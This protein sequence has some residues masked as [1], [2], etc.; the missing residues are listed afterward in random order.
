MVKRTLK[1]IEEVGINALSNTRSVER[2]CIK[3]GRRIYR[4]ARDT[5]LMTKRTRTTT[6]KTKWVLHVRKTPTTI[7]IF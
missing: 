2:D 6:P 1:R 4:T 5:S 3:T 7:K